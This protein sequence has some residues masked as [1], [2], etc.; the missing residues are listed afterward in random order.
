MFFGP[1]WTDSLFP[2][3]AVFRSYLAL[4]AMAS[5]FAHFFWSFWYF[6]SCIELALFGSF[7]F[8]GVRIRLRPLHLEFMGGETKEESQAAQA[9]SCSSRPLLI[10]VDL[11]LFFFI[12]YFLT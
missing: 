2:L 1:L 4:K 11:C 3:S 12:I 10:G 9:K 7:G 5:I 6:I 8:E